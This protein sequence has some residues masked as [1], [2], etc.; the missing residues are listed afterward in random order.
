MSTKSTIAH[1]DDFHLYHEIFEDDFVYLELEGVEFRATRDRVMVPIPLAVWE[2]IRKRGGA[3]LSLAA[4]SDEE[5]RLLVGRVVDERIAEYQEGL[6][7]T[8]DPSHARLF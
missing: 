6:A 4:K 5:L 8:G 2:V 7:R 3:D 1:G